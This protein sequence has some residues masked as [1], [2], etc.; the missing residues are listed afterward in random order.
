MAQVAFHFLVSII[1]IAELA[2]ISRW[3]KALASAIAWCSG[4]PIHGDGAG[5][6]VPLFDRPR[7][8]PLDDRDSI[9]LRGRRPHLLFDP[10]RQ[11]ELLDLRDPKRPSCGLNEG[12]ELLELLEIGAPLTILLEAIEVHLAELVNGRVGSSL[13]LW[14][15]AHQLIELL[16]VSGLLFAQRYLFSA[17]RAIPANS[18]FSEERFRRFVH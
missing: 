1:V 16:E 18:L 8:Q 12:P 17:N 14:P 7:E 3:L 5:R 4:F 11:V 6:D 15:G 2:K 10:G 13:N 9:R